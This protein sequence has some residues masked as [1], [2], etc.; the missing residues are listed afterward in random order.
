MS[1]NVGGPSCLEKR[2]KKHPTPLGR[3]FE[4]VAITVQEQVETFYKHG[5]KSVIVLAGTTGT[6]KTS[7]SLQ[8][9]EKIGGEII[10]ADSMQ[11]YRG[12]DIGTAKATVQERER[13]PHHLIDVRNITEPFNVKDFY[14]EAMQ[15]CHE[16]INRGR[17]P[18]V[19]GGTGFYI[20]AL[21]YG[22]PLGPPADPATRS[23]LAEEEARFGIELLYDKL[24]QLDPLYAATISRNDRHKILRALEII[25]ISGKKVSDFSWKTRTVLDVFDFR[26]WFLFLPRPILYKQLEKRCDQMLEQGLLQEV[27]KLDREGIR[28]N[29]TASQAIGY[30]QTLDFLATAKTEEDYKQYVQQLKQASRH[31]AKRQFT[32]FRKEPHFRWLDLAEHTRDEALE[33]VLS[34]FERDGTEQI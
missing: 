23:L 14:Q 29:S 6:G 9:A 26:C 4:H 15:T 28:Q 3:I 19:V 8:L 32:W 30:R 16:V 33:I 22:P 25:E 13:I 7:F 18:M 12:M 17:T 2:T 31:L 11:V 5:S 34:D 27:V 20:H 24:C 10:S 1:K 21:L